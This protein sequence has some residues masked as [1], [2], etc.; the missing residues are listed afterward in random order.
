[1]HLFLFFYFVQ[2]DMLQAEVQALKLL[3]LTSTPSSPHPV[4]P[5]SPDGNKKKPIFKRSKKKD[6]RP[7]SMYSHQRNHSVSS[8]L[9]IRVFSTLK[10]GSI[11]LQLTLSNAL[12]M[13]VMT[14]WKVKILRCEE[15]LPLQ[16]HSC[17]SLKVPDMNIL[18]N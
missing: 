4:S 14:S 9:Q 3:V 16:V 10:T 12:Y 17:E 15:F 11:L 13:H 18:K 2:I 7:V 6:N 5:N 1:M 8:L